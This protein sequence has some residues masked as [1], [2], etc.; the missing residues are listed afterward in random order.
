[1]SMKNSTDTIGNRSRDL[2]DFSAVPQPTAPPQ[3]PQKN[4][5]YV[6]LLGGLF[7]TFM[8]LE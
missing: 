7:T 2:P 8:Q 3:P 1:M 5:A 4:V 6:I